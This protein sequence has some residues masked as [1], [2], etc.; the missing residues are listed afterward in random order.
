M[1]E[2]LEIPKMLLLFSH[3]LTEDQIQ[4]ANKSLGVTSFISLPVDL[5]DLWRN[6]P[7]TKPS[8]NDFLKPFRKWVGESANQGDCVLIQGD[9]GAVYSM[10]NYSFSLGVVPLYATTERISIETR[11]SENM[12]R[13][14]RTFRHKMFRKYEKVIL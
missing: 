10:V 13:S 9:F 3:E 1:L 8:L 2:V 14:E 12:I 5:Q 6:V 11:T 7:P 4:D